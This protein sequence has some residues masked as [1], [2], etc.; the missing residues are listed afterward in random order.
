MYMGMQTRKGGAGRACAS[1]PVRVTVGRGL[2][3]ER[4]GRLPENRGVNIVAY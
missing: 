2:M 4:T 3:V 1:V